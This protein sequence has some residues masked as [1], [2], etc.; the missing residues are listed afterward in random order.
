MEGAGAAFATGAS[1]TGG[2]GGLIF[3]VID[4]RGSSTAGGGA[5]VVELLPP[6]F[7]AFDFP[8]DSCVPNFDF[9]NTP[10]AILV[11]QA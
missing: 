3:N 2:K 9:G 10:V 11:F 1:L 7:F 8:F 6:S 4:R 5:G